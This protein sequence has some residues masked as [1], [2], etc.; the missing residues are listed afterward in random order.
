MPNLLKVQVISEIEV[1]I[2]D[3]TLLYLQGLK[4]DDIFWNDSVR[5]IMVNNPSSKKPDTIGGITLIPESEL[6]YHLQD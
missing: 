2:D 5:A 1:S 6:P 4:H 3:D